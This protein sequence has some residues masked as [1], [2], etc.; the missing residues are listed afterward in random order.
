M[1]HWIIALSREDMEHCIKVGKFGLNRKHIL[2]RVEKGDKVACYITKEYK[3]IALGEVTEPYYVDD[4]KVFK[5]AGIFPDR[6]DFIAERLPK[7]EEI[8]FMA[9]VD[10][11]S[12]IKNLAYWSAHFRNGIVQISANDWKT[13]LSQTKSVV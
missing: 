7:A 9:V 4:A 12:F 6:F 11:M 8:D 3:V 5:G 1:N 2:G 13:I 10:K